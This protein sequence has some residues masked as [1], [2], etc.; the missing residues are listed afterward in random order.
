MNTGY[1]VER[2]VII[3]D[4]CGIQVHRVWRK[5]DP[6]PRWRRALERVGM[7]LACAALFASI[8][9]ALLWLL[10]LAEGK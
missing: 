2:E 10:I 8:G 7:V 6:R 5:R 4:E 3:A 9:T 1:Y